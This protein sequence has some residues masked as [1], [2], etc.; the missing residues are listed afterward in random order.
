MGVCGR[1]WYV[2]ASGVRRGIV[3]RHRLLTFGDL[4][5]ISGILLILQLAIG[6]TIDFI[7]QMEWARITFL[8]IL[9]FLLIVVLVTRES[10]V[11]AYVNGIDPNAP[12]SSLN[13][14]IR[15]ADEHTEATEDQRP[16]EQALAQPSQSQPSPPLS[17][18]P[19]ARKS[20]NRWGMT[21]KR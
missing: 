16:Q 10:I 1:G 12:I 9:F 21:R 20:K 14:T 11:R 17:V 13:K 6:K 5:I 15:F 18:P 8:W 19:P 3:P 2:L 4:V 7:L